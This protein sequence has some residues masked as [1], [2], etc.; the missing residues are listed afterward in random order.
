M[1]TKK[2]NDKKLKRIKMKLSLGTPKRAY[3]PGKVYRVPEDVPMDT[4]VSWVKSG[5]ASK[6]E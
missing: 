4:A 6:V 1:T 3:E 2:E 5:A